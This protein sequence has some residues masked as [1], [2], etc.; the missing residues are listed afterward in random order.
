MKLA[1]YIDEGLTWVAE[2]P[3]SRDALLEELAGRIAGVVG[4]VEASALYEALL[5][6]ESKGATATP[7][8]V[9]LP[10]A[11]MEGMTRSHVAVVRLRGKV[12]FKSER[13]G[14][15]DLVFVLMGPRNTAWEHVRV[16][17][18]IA[19]VCGAP[20]A[21]ANL[22]QASDGDDLYARLTKEDARHV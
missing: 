16:L 10:H 17:A 3:A 13:C 1:D 7:E 6:R 18:R 21:L 2:A 14:P 20:G 5:L 22:R 4:E 9:A 15:C 19:R 11:M 12:D 8:G